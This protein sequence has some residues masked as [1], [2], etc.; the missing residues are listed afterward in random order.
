MTCFPSGAI[1]A[2]DGKD[3]V[4]AVGREDLLGALFT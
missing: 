2:P 3:G 4:A 1:T